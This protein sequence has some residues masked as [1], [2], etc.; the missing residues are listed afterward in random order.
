MGCFLY[1]PGDKQGAGM[2]G[3]AEARDW[4]QKTFWGGYLQGY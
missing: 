2:K 1:A 4:R 3:R